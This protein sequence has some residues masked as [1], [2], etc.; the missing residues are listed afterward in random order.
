MDIF[1]NRAAQHGHPELID[2]ET[3]LEL[4]VLR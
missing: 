3:P 2:I 1:D 4:G